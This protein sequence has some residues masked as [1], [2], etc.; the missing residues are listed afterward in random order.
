M[1]PFSVFITCSELTNSIFFQT[2]F[3]SDFVCQ[4]CK[5][6]NFENFKD[7]SLKFYLPLL[8]CYPDA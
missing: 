7:Q 1:P 2:A 6:L 8:E 4:L 5:I 3:E